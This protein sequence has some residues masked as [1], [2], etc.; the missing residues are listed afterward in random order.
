MNDSAKGMSK[1]ATK[2]SAM[3]SPRLEQFNDQFTAVEDRNEAQVI[4]PVTLGFYIV[5]S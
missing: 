2:S 3:P 1:V 5:V 4:S